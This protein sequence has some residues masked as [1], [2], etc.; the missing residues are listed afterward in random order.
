MNGATRYAILR[1][2]DYVFVARG[3]MNDT[4]ELP[5]K[6]K[7]IRD[8]RLVY[9]FISI[10]MEKVTV[11]IRRG[12]SRVRNS[13]RKFIRISSDS[14]SKSPN[15]SLVLSVQACPSA[16]NRDYEEKSSAVKREAHE[17]S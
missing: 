5:V 3:R 15:K 11:H 9:L 2:G 16:L 4:S 6:M 1:R 13:S 17:F 10:S 8:L 12:A 7:N 14:K